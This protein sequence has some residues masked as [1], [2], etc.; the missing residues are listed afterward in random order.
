MNAVTGMPEVAHDVCHDRV[1]TWAVD[2]FLDLDQRASVL[3]RLIGST[4]SCRADDADDALLALRVG[5]DEWL[6]AVHVSARPRPAFP[7]GEPP[8]G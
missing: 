1:L 4:R 8:Q 7:G 2:A 3:E 5:R 6:A